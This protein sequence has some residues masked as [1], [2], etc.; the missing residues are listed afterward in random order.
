MSTLQYGIIV[1]NATQSW[2]G[3]VGDLLNG[4]RAAHATTDSITC[5]PPLEIHLAT[6]SAPARS[7]SLP[8]AS[9]STMHLRVP[10]TSDLAVGALTI[11]HKRENAVDF[12]EPCALL[13]LVQSRRFTF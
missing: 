9:H 4:V 6:A 13:L 8:T 1:D 3:L 11:T 5:A 10:Q 2:N 7:H 12:T